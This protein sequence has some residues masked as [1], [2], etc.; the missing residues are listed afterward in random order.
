MPCQVVN[1]FCVGRVDT[2]P[3]LDQAWRARLA[4]DLA[5]LEEDSEDNT[6]P[7]SDDLSL[8]DPF[9]RATTDC[10]PSQQDKEDKWLLDALSQLNPGRSTFHNN[11]HLDL[12]RLPFCLYFFLD[13]LTYNFFNIFCPMILF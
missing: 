10:G 12:A 13:T 3:E 6:G 2:E 7:R 1:L 9:S 11:L 4:E 5:S 8:F